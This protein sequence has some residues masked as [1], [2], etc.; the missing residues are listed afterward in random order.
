[1]WLYW[2]H[3]VITSDSD[4]NWDLDR[5]GICLEPQPSA[6]SLDLAAA[7]SIML[8]D[9]EPILNYVVSCGLERDLEVE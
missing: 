9:S 6:P 3:S 5:L 4:R 1:M 7:E 8:W 2:F